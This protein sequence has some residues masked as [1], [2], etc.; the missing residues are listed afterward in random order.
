MMM[1]A[2]QL[3]ELRA[4]VVEHFREDIARQVADGVRAGSV[5]ADM[6]DVYL[7][8]TMASETVRASIEA[9]VARH[10]GALH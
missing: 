5:P 6:V 4:S 1:D 7:E 9:F 3:T 2:E 8:A 10:A